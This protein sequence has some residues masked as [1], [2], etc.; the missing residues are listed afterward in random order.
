MLPVYVPSADDSNLR[1]LRLAHPLSSRE[2]PI[3]LH[4]D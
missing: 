4:Y 3:K 1:T 2:N